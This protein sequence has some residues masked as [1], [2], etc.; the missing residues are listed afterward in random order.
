MNLSVSKVGVI[1]RREYL[2]TVRRKAFV[3]TLLITP[4]IF[5]LGGVVSTKMSIN[6][7][8]AKQ[9]E[10]RVVALVD[11]SGLY[12]NAPLTYEY[13]PEIG[14]ASCRERV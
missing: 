11:S 9:A 8:L 2:T 1:A 6:S 7:S 14:R 3:V 4:L 10:A 13:Q 5:F 12:A